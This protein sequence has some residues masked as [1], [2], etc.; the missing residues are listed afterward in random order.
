MQ[1]YS[2]YTLR[3]T[4]N[5]ISSSDRAYCKIAVEYKAEEIFTVGGYVNC[6]YANSTIETNA[7]EFKTS[8]DVCPNST[9]TV[10]T[11]SET[12]CGMFI[13]FGTNCR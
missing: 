6:G 4:E 8:D 2:E 10:K 7:V 1:V 5:L 9:S 11:S 3:I 13:L 12:F